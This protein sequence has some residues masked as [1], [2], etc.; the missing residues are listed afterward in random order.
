MYRSLLIQKIYR[1]ISKKMKNKT[2]YLI[3]LISVLY[4]SIIFQGSY[5]LLIE[6][7]NKAYKTTNPVLS[8][9]DSVIY[10]W[11]RTWG[12]VGDEFCTGVTL[13]SSSNIY[14]AGMTGSF[15]VGAFDMALVKY[16]ESGVLQWNNTWG[17]IGSESC[18]GIAVDSLDNI[19]I[20]GMSNISGMGFWDLVLVKYDNSG[21]QQWNRS[22]GGD[23]WEEGNGVAVDSSDNVYFTGATASFGA[24]GYDLVLLKYNSSGG[25]Q[26]NTTWGGIGD[27]G[28]IGVAMDLTD[29][30]YV[31]GSTESFGAGADDLV[32]VKY[33]SSGVEQWNRTWGG[34]EYEH[35]TRVLVDSLD[36]VYLAGN[37]QSFG[38]GN[39]DLFLVK[40]DSSGVKQWNRTWGGISVELTMGLAVDSLGNIFLTGFT[41]SFGG[42][43]MFLVKY[44]SSGVLQ[45]NITWGGT[46]LVE[47][48]AIAID[49][50]DNVYLAGYTENFGAGFD[51]VLVKFSKA[52]KK[53]SKFIPGF[54]TIMLISLVSIITAIVVK[55][56]FKI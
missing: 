41:T 33:D 38:S 17:G 10:E 16:N 20:S 39:W 40:Y 25:L 28:G 5:N 23:N 7:N 43:N 50:L 21:V 47:S 46:Y 29:N 11:N 9:S 31:T 42:D 51:M 4:F 44:D 8:T 30:I 1:K 2:H 56:K 34:I 37:T 12:G 26:W 35:A 6:R 15:G 27:D 13:D 48:W 49:S 36:N 32:L 22:W 55:R 18:W 54:D 19:Y 14:L 52:T 3:I 53:D 45:W 24:G